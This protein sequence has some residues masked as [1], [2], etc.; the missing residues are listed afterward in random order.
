MF[1]YFSY[2]EPV[3]QGLSFEPNLGE[4]ENKILNQIGEI[5]SSYESVMINAGNTKFVS[6]NEVGYSQ[7][8]FSMNGQIQLFEEW[9]H[10]YH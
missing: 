3:N 10:S 1:N 7:S 9:F 6:R 8:N 4:F 2:S 5:C